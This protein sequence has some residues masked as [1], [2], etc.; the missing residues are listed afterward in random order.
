MHYQILRTKKL[1]D[2]GSISGSAKHLFREIDTPNADPQ[3]T[4][5]NIILVGPSTSDG[6]VN[7]IGNILE[8]VDKSAKKSKSGFGK[9]KKES[10]PVLAIEYMITYSPGAIENPKQ[11]FDDALS[12]LKKKHGADNVVSAVVHMDETTPHMSAFVVP[13]VERGG[14]PRKYNVADGKDENGK[15]RR[16]TITKMVGAER[17]LSAKAYIGSRE[18]MSAMQT[19]FHESVGVRH[20]LARGIK[21]SKATH[22]TVK[23]WYGKIPELPPRVAH[24]TREQLVEFGQ[25]AYVAAMRQKELLRK[26]QLAAEE[27]QRAAQ[28]TL[29]A[30]REQIQRAEGEHQAQLMAA[31]ATIA[32]QAEQIRSLGQAIRDHAAQFREWIEGVLTRVWDALSSPTG[33]AAARAELQYATAELRGSA[34]LLEVPPLRAEVRQLA[35]GTWRAAVIDLGEV[36]QWSEIY[37]DEGDAREAAERWI[38]E[39][40]GPAPGL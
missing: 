10:N 21:G 38:E 5:N 15:L 11:Y 25:A 36:E 7:A 30:L 29:E 24:A 12:W 23:S 16:K 13:I 37:A 17:W 32:D 39:Q 34:E 6:I 20:G 35:D 40:A 31:E 3:R 9:T 27:Q 26:Q 14:K 18:K 8:T 4:P 33:A 1:S 22:R 19:D 2:K 28:R